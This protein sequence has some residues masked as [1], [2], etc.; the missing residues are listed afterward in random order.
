MKSAQPSARHV[1]TIIFFLWTDE[2]REGF[3]RQGVPPFP[4]FS[5]PFIFFICL[6]HP[7]LVS[8]PGHTPGA[9]LL[10]LSASFLALLLS[11]NLGLPKWL[12]KP[13]W[14]SEPRGA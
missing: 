5:V 9:S 8:S 1:A 4:I 14:I 11:S 7:F 13:S 2:R 12:I 6:L 10:L 3:I